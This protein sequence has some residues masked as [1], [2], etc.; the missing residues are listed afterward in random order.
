MKLQELFFTQILEGMYTIAGPVRG[1]MLPLVG[2][3]GDN[4]SITVDLRD[5]RIDKDNAEGIVIKPKFTEAEQTN[6]ITKSMPPGTLF[7]VAQP[8]GGYMTYSV[9]SIQGNTV[10]ATNPDNPDAAVVRIIGMQYYIDVDNSD[11][12]ISFEDERSRAEKYQTINRLGRG[13]GITVL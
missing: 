10:V 6:F 13:A 7:R 3:E 1:D 2:N 11:G 4:T 8:G 5:K 12:M 9:V